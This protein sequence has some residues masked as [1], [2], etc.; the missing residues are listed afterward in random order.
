[1]KK[2]KNMVSLLLAAVM[3]ACIAGCGDRS[4]TDKISMKKGEIAAQGDY[5]KLPS[6]DFGKQGAPIISGATRQAG[7]GETVNVT[8]AGFSATDLKAYIYTQS[9]EKDGKSY[10]CKFKAITDS[11]A[12]VTVDSG[13]KYGVYVLYFENSS[14]KSNYKLIN[15]PK[16]WWIGISE[17]SA[18]ESIGIYGENLTN[19]NK[20]STNVFLTADGQY[21]KVNVEYADPYKVTVKIPEGLEVGK[22]YEVVLHNGHGGEFGFAKA[23]EKIT[24]TDK[25]TTDFSSGKKIDV[26]EHGADPADDGKD[27]SA[28]ILSAIASASSGDTIYFPNGVYNIDY[29]VEVSN[30]LRFLG[31][32]VDGVEIIVGS[33]NPE[34]LFEIY[35]GPVEFGNLSFYE[36]RENGKL[37]ATMIYFKGGGELKK[38]SELNI[39]DCR[40]TQST[41]QAALSI[42]QLITAENTS[43]FIF[44]NNEV[45]ATE[46]CW[47]NSCQKVFMND[48]VYYGNFWTGRHYNQNATLFW[49]SS[50]FDVSNNE[51]SSFDSKTDET[52]TLGK[53]DR[54]TGRCFVFQGYLENVYVANNNLLE[55]GLPDDNAGEQVLIEACGIIGYGNP[56][57]ADE[58]SVTFDKPKFN[59]GGSWN[60]VVGVG[61]TVSVIY[62]TGVG[63]Y[64]K[65]KSISGNKVTLEEN[66]DI[67]P[68]SDSVVTTSKTGTNVVVYKN[69]ISGYKNY[70]ENPGATCGVSTTAQLYNLKIVDNT[71]SN[72]PVGIFMSQKY[73]CGTNGDPNVEG[74]TFGNY[75]SMVV[76]NTIE[77]TCKG[78]RF[79][80]YEDMPKSTARGE[81]LYLNVGNVVRNNTIRNTTDFTAKNW[82]GTGGMAVSLGG[83]AL[84]VSG[85]PTGTW[86]G[87]W[88]Q[89]V[90]FENNVFE[91]NV[92]N[93]LLRKHQGNN[94]FR[95]NT[96]DSGD[97]C[98]LEA[99]I[100]PVSEPILF[101]D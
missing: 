86:P 39:H 14:G 13:V 25:K 55:V 74:W 90:I 28:G 54:T 60:R 64:R 19:G 29:T 41:S 83:Y 56:M 95:N 2:F 70:A 80:T 20:D 100:V 63:Q 26:T 8:G 88:I 49:R 43:G 1:M 75:W 87:N 89:D 35:E 98:T 58:N 33:K 69:Q 50:K 38:Y 94:V 82:A 23:E 22:E 52:Q 65:I 30:K 45:L 42:Q 71:F 37:A 15:D 11:E 16:I 5:F 62:G 76:G 61:D 72:M 96:A 36:V 17:V 78:I 93:I 97:V 73:R 4:G 46:I 66:W 18:G 34:K 79:E 21:C 10:E 47:T 77:N 92:Q 99:L 59:E 3:I 84:T 67:I 9:S 81:L 12:A 53:A 31:E 7:P 6:D 44:R 27:D 91:K 101:N 57:A 40:F 24:F 85:S 51:F 48:N 32:S 68:S